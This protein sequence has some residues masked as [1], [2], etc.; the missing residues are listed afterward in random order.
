MWSFRAG[1]RTAGGAHCSAPPAT[2]A[3]AADEAAAPAPPSPPSSSASTSS[4]VDAPDAAA[5]LEPSTSARSDSEDGGD[6]TSAAPDH[7]HPP[8]PVAA[9]LAAHA[10]A[11]AGDV[12]ATL[13]ALR[14]LPPASRVTVDPV[15]GNTVLQVAAM[16]G[17]AD[18]VKALLETGLGGPPTAR[19]RGRWSALDEASLRDD[20]S[21]TQALAA[22]TVADAKARRAAARAALASALASAPDFRMSVRWELG[23]PLLGPL[24]RRVA[25]HDTY[26]VC[27]VGSSLRIDGSLRGLA[28]P[29]PGR[30]LPE[31]RRGAF[32]LVWHAP[33]G[34]GGSGGG[35]GRAVAWLI[36]RERNSYIDVAKERHDVL[37]GGGDGG[38][39]GTGARN[40]PTD[41][42]ASA[43]R[44][45][46]SRARLRPGP[47]R[48][49]PARAWHG[50]GP[51]P[52][53]RLAGGHAAR[54]FDVA[55]PLS[56]HEAVRGRLDLPAGATF[57]DYL[58]APPAA[59]TVRVAAVDPL[60]LAGV[61]GRGGGG[62]GGGGA[63]PSSSSSSSARPLSARVWL[64]GPD[65]PLPGT[66]LAAVLELAA[67]AS[68]H[69]GPLGRFA[70]KAADAAAAAAAGADAVAARSG[71]TAPAPAP[72]SDAGG[73]GVAVKFQVP[74][75]LTVHASVAVLSC[76]RLGPGDP[77]VEGAAAWFGLPPGCRLKAAS[78]LAAGRRVAAAAAA[79]RAAEEEGAFPD[80]T[81]H[82]AALVAPRPRGE[83]VLSSTVGDEYDSFE[84]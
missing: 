62:G 27:K 48:F 29:R 30:A 24:L 37:K 47:L 43:V 77:E 83:S 60:A 70:R 69:L 74:L 40:P 71:K 13:S 57:E 75:M 52:V 20:A 25:P 10:A 44:S 17:H 76:E 31:W 8:P 26:T 33:G 51:A 80:G 34:G 16:R 9:D 79:A 38:T 46:G 15:H 64:A 42:V 58:A 11:W 4:F 21:I 36:D 63:N 3:T 68:P 78:D 32:G 55:L 53:E 23:S 84:F 12:D 1:R 2:P 39:G 41:A 50:L 49:T 22:A 5:W 56:T 19:G 54:P 7:H 18:L 45:A 82:L 65:F 14:T 35:S 67:A 66:L 81:P 73:A 72:P 61:P 6:G 28:E 59:D